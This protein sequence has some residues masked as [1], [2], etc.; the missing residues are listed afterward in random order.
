MNTQKPVCAFLTKTSTLWI[1]F[2]TTLLLFFTFRIVA[3]TWGFT[4][5][6]SISSPEELRSLIAGMSAEQRIS[7]AWATCTLDVAFPIS[8]GLLFAG[9][10]LRFFPKYG[11][12]LALP[13]FLAIPTDLFEGVIQ[14]LAL[15][16]TA[17][18]LYLKAIVTPLKATLLL[19]GLAIAIVG[20]TSWL[21]TK[22]RK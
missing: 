2:V 1:L 19:T 21:L 16:D 11:I 20:W 18:L 12:Y 5:I 8:A 22:F 17:D 14:V 6:D 3:S 4:F 7:H 13:G 9:V 15:T 10:A